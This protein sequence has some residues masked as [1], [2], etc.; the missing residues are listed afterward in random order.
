MNM[1]VNVTVDNDVKKRLDLLGLGLE[2]Y[3][4]KLIYKDIN[5]VVRLGNGFHY[6]KA[7][8]KLYS[9]AKYEVRLTRI[10]EKLFKLLL[11]NKGCIVSIEDIKA[12]VWHGKNMTRFTLRNKIKTLRDKTFYELIKNHSNIG[13]EMQEL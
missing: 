12:T 2:E 8:E 11:E 6:D 7:T 1:D 13:Y 10:E 3:V 5:G 4:N 9:G